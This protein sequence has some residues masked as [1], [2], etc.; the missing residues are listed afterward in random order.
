M[1]DTLSHQNR[2]TAREVRAL[3]YHCLIN[4]PHSVSPPIPI[5]PFISKGAHPCS[6]VTLSCPASLASCSLRQP[7]DL[8]FLDSDTCEDYSLAVL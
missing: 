4:R 2:I 3:C 8:S 5:M 7:L 6:R 1:A